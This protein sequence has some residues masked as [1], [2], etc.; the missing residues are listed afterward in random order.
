M[1][2]FWDLLPRHI[3]QVATTGVIRKLRARLQRRKIVPPEVQ[4]SR[5]R[6]LYVDLAVIS[7]HDAGTGIQRVVRA[8]ALALREEG[9]GEWDIRFVAAD[10]RRPYHGIAWPDAGVIVDPAEMEG[11]PGDLLIGLDFS[12]DTIRRYR[13]QLTQFRRDGGRLWFLIFDLLPVE[14]SDWFSPNNVLRYKAWLDTLVGLAEG[15][16][17]ISEQTERDL[18]RVLAARYG[19]TAG[20]RTTVVAMGHDIRESL[21]NPSLATDAADC[22]RFDMSLPFSLMVGTLEPR[23]GHADILAAFSALWRQGADDRLVLVGRLGWN[24]EDLRDAIRTHPEHGGKLFWF[25]DVDDLELE[26]IYKACYGVIIASHAEGFGLPL[27]E[28]LGHDKPVLARDLPIFRVHEALGL[29]YFPAGANADELGACI[30]QW[31][32]QAQAGRIKVARPSASWK[33][34]AQGLLSAIA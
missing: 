23:K 18:R 29:H 8:L 28:A 31:A 25:D 11:R 30:R 12:L 24:V 4:S 27:I 33:A 32:E 10:R 16:L 9:A 5:P 15:F 6:R 7:R 2:P 26:R 17:C 19:L 20:Y 22:A 21:H 1:K 3:E 34:S 14:R 13:R